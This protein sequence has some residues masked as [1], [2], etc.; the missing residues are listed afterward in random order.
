VLSKHAYDIVIVGGGPI[1]AALAIALRNS[2]LA[3]LVLEA[4]PDAGDSD[5]ARTLAMS[6][7]SRLILERLGIWSQI[8]PV[9]PIE[10]IH[11]SQRGGFGRTLLSADEAGLPALGY[12]VRYARLQQAFGKAIESEH[13]TL[14]AGAEVIGMNSTD[15][16]V[17]I[18]FLRQGAT[19]SAT[20]RLLV[21]AD[22][23]ANAEL[24]ARASVKVREYGQDAVVGLVETSQPHGR[25]AYERFTPDGPIAL[26]PF[27]SRY[28]LV[29][30]ATPETANGLMELP[31]N[32]FLEKLQRHFG[33]RA[34][35][36]ISIEARA[37]FPLILRYA[38]DPVLPRAVMLGN[39]AQALH[40]IAGQGFNLGL[41]DAWELGEILLLHATRDPGS[42]E[43]LS[44]YR[45]ARRR[46]RLRG[47]ALTHSLV[48]IFS[49]DLP[50]LR[51]TRGA[52]LALLDL[53]PPAKRAFMQRMIFGASR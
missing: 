22:G 11:V 13:T 32:S 48:K 24:R 8:E 30:T 2:G 14:I 36:F 44:D 35:R 38:A 53:V 15:E 20:A 29:W 31:A 6:Y 25:K 27:E 37:R 16:G 10:S 33:D 3:V 21:I 46:D 42:G 5:D 9:T 40:P 12:V 34:G 49:N 26:L 18:G 7:G 23:G 28:A 50:P 47:I 43:C 45:A 17:C 51:A 39:A 19:L 4:R 1:G 41:R 52:A